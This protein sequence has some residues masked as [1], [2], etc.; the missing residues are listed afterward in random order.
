MQILGTLNIILQIYRFLGM[1][2]KN[3]GSGLILR[4]A[5]YLQKAKLADLWQPWMR[6]YFENIKNKLELWYTIQIMT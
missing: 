4:V 6:E 3:L 1:P 2:N 5:I